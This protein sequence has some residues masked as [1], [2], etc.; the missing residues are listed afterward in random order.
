M[1]ELSDPRVDEVK[2]AL[3]SR[4]VVVFEDA[5]QWF[6]VPSP[7]DCDEWE[8]QVPHPH[9]QCRTIIATTE[10]NED[11]ANLI[12]NAPRFLVALLAALREKDETIARL[13][14]Q[15]AATLDPAP[16]ALYPIIRETVPELPE[17]RSRHLADQL[18]VRFR[19]LFGALEEVSSPLP[20]PDLSAITNAVIDWYT[21]PG[22]R[23][24]A[25]LPNVIAEAAQGLVLPHRE[26]KP[27]E[28]RMCI[29]SFADDPRRHTDPTGHDRWGVCKE[30]GETIRIDGSCVPDHRYP[31][32]RRELGDNT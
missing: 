17:E 28:P 26:P 4:G 22:Q 12:A 18:S 29:K 15:L 11:V 2:A 5:G 3:D 9:P 19:S 7:L 21:A 8:I 10:Q 32:A 27:D 24:V 31:E 25:N 16:S 14:A 20:Q 23:I 13:R 30:C 1:T 6:V